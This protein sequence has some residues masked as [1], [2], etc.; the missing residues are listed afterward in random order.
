[1]FSTI[2]TTFETWNISFCLTYR[3]YLLVSPTCTTFQTDLAWSLENNL[4]LHCLHIPENYRTLNEGYKRIEQSKGAVTT[5][6]L[7]QGDH[8]VEESTD[9]Y[10]NYLHI[11]RPVNIVGSLDVLDKSNIVVVGG[12]SIN[13][14][15]N[16]HGNVHVEHLTIRGSKYSGVRGNSSFTLNDLT[17]DQCGGFGVY[18]GGSSTH[19]ANYELF[20]QL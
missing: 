13:I 9:E 4:V 19:N 11:K 3:N 14:D 20:I 12:F 8:V 5:I 16:I 7:G 1:L 17:I 15:E 10:V 2:T 18:A 6:V